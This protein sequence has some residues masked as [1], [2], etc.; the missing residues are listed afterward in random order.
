MS[1]QKKEVSE[2]SPQKKVIFFHDD[3][4]GIFCAGLLMAKYGPANLQPVSSNDRWR[5]DDL[6][7]RARSRYDHITIV[8]YAFHQQADTWYDHHRVDI[9]DHKIISSNADRKW[10]HDTKAKSAFGLIVRDVYGYEIPKNIVDLAV[11]IDMYDSAAFPNSRYIFD[12]TDPVNMIYSAISA[13]ENHKHVK[14]ILYRHL[15]SIV[16]SWIRMG[17]NDND[18]KDLLSVA[19][20]TPA[21]VMSESSRAGKASSAMTVFGEMTL[22]ISGYGEFPRYAEYLAIDKADLNSVIK[23]NVRLMPIPWQKGMMRVSIG[24]NQFYNGK[25]KLLDI[26]KMLQESPLCKGGG[27][28]SIG[29]GVLKESDMDEFVE[30]ITLQLSG[31]LYQEDGMLEKLGVDAENDDFEKTASELSKEA[32]VNMDEARK[33]VQK[34]AKKTKTA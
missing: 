10:I 22:L 24:V 3:L 30:L 26:G 11:A 2:I 28:K 25:G 12:T 29:A 32:H 19:D 13:N 33:Q 23:Y 27:H 17:G 31:Q 7:K 5:F 18:L 1:D 9:N 6:V 16:A 8:D 4:D 21:I 34:K 15:A 14:C 20:V